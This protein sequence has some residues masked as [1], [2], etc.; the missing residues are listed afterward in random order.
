MKVLISTILPIVSNLRPTGTHYSIE[1]LDDI[2]KDIDEI[3]ESLKKS[4]QSQ[5]GV[6]VVEH[7][8]FIDSAG[9]IQDSL[10]SA[11]GV[12][13]SF[14]GTPIVVGNIE[15]AIIE[16]QRTQDM[17]V[18]NN[19]TD[20]S[21][22][23]ESEVFYS[24]QSV[25]SEVYYNS[26]SGVNEE[27]RLSYANVVRFCDKREQPVLKQAAVNM[28]LPTE[29]KKF[30]R[31]TQRQAALQKKPTLKRNTQSNAAASDSEQNCE[32]PSKDKPVSTLNRNTCKEF[33]N[34]RFSV[35]AV[36]D[37][38]VSGEEHVS[39]DVEDILVNKRMYGGGKREKQHVKKQ[40]EQS[41]VES[42]GSVQSPP[43]QPV[44]IESEGRVSF[45][46]P[47][48][49]TN[50]ISN[51]QCELQ[52]LETTTRDTSIDGERVQPHEINISANESTRR[53]HSN[54]TDNKDDNISETPN[55]EKSV[56]CDNSTIMD[57]SVDEII[58]LLNCKENKNNENLSNSSCTNTTENNI[59]DEPVSLSEGQVF[60][61]YKEFKSKFDN[62]CIQN[63]HPVKT[64]SSKKTEDKSISHSDFPFQQIRFT[65][66][67]AGK[68]RIRSQGKRPLQ[69]YLPCECPMFLRLKLDQ[70]KMQYKITKLEAN[71]N[72]TT[73]VG[74]FKHYSTSR[75][76]GT[77]EK[78]NIEALIN[79]NV[80]TKNIKA[81]VKEKTGKA[82]QTKDINNL[83]GE[84]T[85]QKEGGLSR[86][87]LLGIALD[88]LKENKQATTV[89]DVN[90]SKTVELIYIQTG[91]MKE[92]YNKYPEILFLDTTYNVN[93]E[94]YPLFAIMAED[95]DGRGRPVAYCFVRSETKENLEK[96]L[97]YFCEFN[98]TSK[99]RVVMVDKDISVINA[100]KCKLPNANVLL[101]KF[102][103]M[104]YFKKK[105][106]DL[107]CKHKE[108]QELGEHLHKLIDSRDKEH[109][110]ALYEKLQSFSPEFVNYFN[111]NWHTC[112]ELWVLHFRASLR[113]HGN[114][115]NNKIESHNQK[116]KNYVSKHMNLPQ[117][118]ENLDKFLDDTYSR[119]AFTR[120]ANLKTKID[121]RNTEK[122]VI[123]YS[124]L[125]NSKAF[126]IVNDE[127]RIL[128]SMKFEIEEVNDAYKVK[129]NVKSMSFAIT[130][131][132]SMTEC[133]CLTFCN[134]GLPC[135]H[136][137]CMPK[138]AQ[139]HCV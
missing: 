24:N 103:V 23:D 53:D 60:E 40:H 56:L 3:N 22:S 92:H 51:I 76:I 136:I 12:H 133:S 7:P 72:H 33:Y 105:V 85:K 21:Q 73:S 5:D 55:N 130:V 102:H 45:E 58:E 2:N 67:H 54:V 30:S 75:R 82:I 83:K 8:Q 20:R 52:D 6:F 65:C 114:N 11:D 1:E 115:T 135:R 19:I 48:V 123:K 86:G 47:I 110:D 68:P 98:D 134:F 79:M 124:L 89:C 97:D 109:Y 77:A 64:D 62:W 35:L 37:D 41:V 104:K 119:S 117:A 28:S 90:D 25:E 49:E 46:V 113:T 27:K 128:D 131:S 126:Q 94:G 59:S 43:V 31:R 106:S 112:Q 78:E 26:N 107:D 88:K 122:D 34:N 120:Y 74:E 96:V 132:K 32:L 29:T 38:S 16:T 39:D 69:A 80:D 118:I 9:R 70:N 42:V 17:K 15:S 91:E 71:H 121:A 111:E 139:K 81:F 95:G 93:I 137:I 101:C 14:E 127:Y 50:G 87:K 100:L 125:C 44:G 138:T 61:S 18:Y 63:N 66:K 57:A 99:T 129:Y 116:L 84:I 13:L 36:D 108:R 10:L 4:A